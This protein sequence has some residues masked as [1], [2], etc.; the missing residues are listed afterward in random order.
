M[1]PRKRVNLGES[2]IDRPQL[3]GNETEVKLQESGYRV[4]DRERIGSD[5]KVTTVTQSINKGWKT[6]AT[7]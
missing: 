1:T 7:M 2:E 5:E 6:Q 4:C 3:R